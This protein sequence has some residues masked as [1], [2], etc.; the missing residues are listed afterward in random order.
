MTEKEKD[1]MEAAT[2]NDNFLQQKLEEIK[3]IYS[4]L[5]F[6]NNAIIKIAAD[7]IKHA[8]SRGKYDIKIS[9]TSETELLIYTE[10]NDTYNNIII[11]KDGDVEFMHIPL[12]RTKTYNEHFFIEDI[13]T[14]SI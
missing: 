11:D 10:D 9:R 14:L 3:N 6:E 13:W 4:I 7:I 1:L 5:N 12:D 2:L 8:T